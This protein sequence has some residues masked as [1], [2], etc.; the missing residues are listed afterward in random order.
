MTTT[1]NNYI[2]TLDQISTQISASPNDGPVS[3]LGAMTM[4]P[5]LIQIVS[6]TNFSIKITPFVSD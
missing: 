6:K 1:K 3:L 5:E 2:A 4:Y